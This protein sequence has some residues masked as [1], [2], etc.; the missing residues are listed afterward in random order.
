MVFEAERVIAATGFA[1]PLLDLPDLGV[2][3]FYQERL[4]AQ[5]AHWES[6]AVRGIFFA[7][8][9]SQGHI[10]LKKYGRPGGGAAVHGF[11]YSAKVMAGYIAEDRLGISVQHPRL[12]ADRV[13]PYLT[14]EATV[15]PELWH[16]QNY[17]ARTV[18]FDEDRG[19][20][21]EGIQP[22]QHFVDT[23]GP[24]AVAVAVETD[25]EGD[26]HPA[27]YVRRQGKVDEQ[28]LP[29]SPLLDFQG[30]EHRA[31]LEALLAEF[32]R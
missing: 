23:N 7:G 22:L 12:D 30:P 6:A 32:L 25:A 16:Q 4:P 13:V 28:A 18:S 29:G 2:P 20:V 1:T 17:L 5:T 14:R 31:E 15:A 24:D 11:R 27:V 3:T 10:G 21:D 19:I 9:I 26:I 8:S